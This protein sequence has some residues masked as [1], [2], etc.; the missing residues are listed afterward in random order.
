MQTQ[1]C[2]NANSK[3]HECTAFVCGSLHICVCGFLRLPRRSSIQRCVFFNMDPSVSRPDVALMVLG[4]FVN[5]CVCICESL[6]AHRHSSDPVEERLS[7]RMREGRPRR[8]TAN[9]SWWRRRREERGAVCAWNK[10]AHRGRHVERGPRSQR[11]LLSAV[12]SP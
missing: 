3:M 7:G 5:L 8:A 2:T 12:E 4:A 1:R 9:A 6:R 11:L 10:Q